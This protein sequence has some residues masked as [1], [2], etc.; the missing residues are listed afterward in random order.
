M[1]MSRADAPA[2]ITGVGVVSPLGV[3]I[4][5]FA[6]GFF[7]RDPLRQGD[8]GIPSLR[9]VPDFE[10]SCLVDIDDFNLSTDSKYALGA[11]TLALEHRALKCSPVEPSLFGLVTATSCCNGNPND[12]LPHGSQL[13]SDHLSINGYRH[14]LSGD[15][16]CGARAMQQGWDA[17]SSGQCDMLLA[18]GFDVPS[19]TAKDSLSQGLSAVLGEGAA[20][21]SM[22]SEAALDEAAANPICRLASAVC[23]DIE[24]NSCSSRKSS[25]QKIR[26]HLC[27]AVELALEK[28]GLWEGDIGAVFLCSGRDTSEVAREAEA[29]LLDEVSRVPLSSVKECVGETFAASFP[30]EC[31]A[32]TLVLNRGC[33][34]GGVSLQEVTNGIEIWV[35]QEPQRLLG[36][37]V[38]V[39]GC[40]DT[41]AAAA[42]LTRE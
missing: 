35:E 13:I 39:I 14:S 17:V 25:R 5:Q 38:L 36:K 24:G 42:L 4:E 41:T 10:I 3:G 29:C 31:A 26:S 8:G 1:A 30:L 20:F 32:A 23:V 11:A 28:A 6:R 12:E 19:R 22:E 34:P 21:L 37:A 18:G 27:Q 7:E 16:L 40:S 9:Q 15:C 2:F 33:L